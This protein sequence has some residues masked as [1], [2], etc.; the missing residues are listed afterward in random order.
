M[1]DEHDQPTDHLPDDKLD[2]PLSDYHR[3]RIEEGIAEIEVGRGIP[4]AEVVAEIERRR[5]ARV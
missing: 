1:Q 4:H 2:Q 5:R 3:A